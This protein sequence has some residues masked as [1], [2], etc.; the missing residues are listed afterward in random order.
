MLTLA[1]LARSLRRIETGLS[2]TLD[3]ATNEHPIDPHE[4]RVLVIQL[5]CQAEIIEKGLVE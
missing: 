2:D 1:A 3:N 5:G 4:L